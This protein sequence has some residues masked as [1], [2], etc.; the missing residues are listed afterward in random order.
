MGARQP[1]SVD[2]LVGQ[3]LRELRKAKKMTLA[4]LAEDTGVSWQQIQKY[5]S[6]MHRI[7]AGILWTLSRK[8]RVPIHTFFED[9]FLLGG[10]AL[11]GQQTPWRQD[12]AI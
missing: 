2:I 12:I 8:L 11:P 10:T 3:R 1:S 5:E 4:D 6:G 7:S 9:A